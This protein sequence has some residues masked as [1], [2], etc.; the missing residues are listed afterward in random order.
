ILLNW[1]L[2][3]VFLGVLVGIYFIYKAVTWRQKHPKA[4]VITTKRVMTLE[5][6]GEVKQWALHSEVRDVVAKRRDRDLVKNDGGGFIG[7]LMEKAANAAM[8]HVQDQGD[9]TSNLY[10]DHADVVVLVLANGQRV[11]WQPPGP[12]PAGRLLGRLLFQNSAN[13]E[14]E[15]EHPA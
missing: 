14:Y 6:S 1:I 5:G 10:W 8:N 2:G 12:H 3:I 15:A 7:N 4:W 11:D 13:D 9:K